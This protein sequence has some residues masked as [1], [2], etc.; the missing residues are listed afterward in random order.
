MKRDFLFEIGTEELPSGYIIPALKEMKAML[1]KGFEDAGIKFDGIEVF[2]SPRRLT[3]MVRGLSVFGEG[4]VEEVAGPPSS[5]A[6]DEDGRPTRT[7]IG[8]ARAHGVDP[9][10]L[11]VKETPKGKRVFVVKR[12]SGVKTISYLKD[13]LPS[14]ISSISFP[15]SMRWGDGDLRFARP[16]RWI[17]AVFGDE[18]VEF[19]LNGIRSGRTTY[20]HRFLHPGPIDIYDVEGYPGILMEI[21]K[22]VV[23]PEMRARMIEEQAVALASSV[24]GRPLFPEGLLDR[25]A[26][27]VEYPTALLGKFEERFLELPKPVLISSMVEHQHYFPVVDP[28]GRIMP[29]FVAVR[30]GD[31]RNIDLVRAG[32]ERVLRARLADASF[33]LEEDLKRPLEDRLEGEKRVIFQERLGSLYDKTMRLVELVGWLSSILDPSISETV[34][35]A[36]LLSKCDLLTEMVQEF[37]N[38]QGIMGGEYARIQG[39][40]EGVCRAIAEHYLPRSSSDPVPQSME[41]AILSLADK[42]DN[43]VGYIG[44]GIMPTGSED[45]YAIRRQA[46]G[47]LR[48]LMEKGIRIGIRAMMGKALELLSNRIILGK[49]EIFQNLSEII[50][51][52]LETILQERGV[53]YDEIEAVLEIG[54]DDIP[55]LIL[56]ADAIKSFR[57]FEP[58]MIAVKRAA[59]IVRIAEGKGIRP[60]PFDPSMLSEPAEEELYRQASSME[61][62]AE[63]LASSGRYKEL[64]SLLSKLKPYIDRLFDEVMVMVEDERI[65]DNR[66]ALLR[67]IVG[68]F[69]K[70]GDFSRI[71]EAS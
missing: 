67:W 34:K 5:A 31:E 61:R 20:G 55:D 33:F 64:L 51:G 42:L 21:G 68:F 22:V 41:G 47:I 58:L 62:E 59:N 50:R 2:G 29:Y 6:F 57:G 40:E 1:E 24:G 69:R 12:V 15:K 32:N 45:P 48:I 11:V 16:I 65:R 13:L 71:T 19:E 49:E 18:V 8:F 66:L 63:I 37:P 27:L 35:R 54:F 53:R 30:N 7:A 46:S 38:L 44:V 70:V 25:V 39:E 36:A 4:R 10:E 17:L 26:N 52:R 43:L 3:A 60:K 28:E 14:M 23:S 9:S 56:R